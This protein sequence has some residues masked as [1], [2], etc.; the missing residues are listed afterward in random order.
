MFTDTQAEIAAATIP[1]GQVLCQIAQAHYDQAVDLRRVELPRLSATDSVIPVSESD[2]VRVKTYAVE[3]IAKIGHALEEWV[4]AHPRVCGLGSRIVDDNENS[5]L[6]P[7]D[8]RCLIEHLDSCDSLLSR[9]IYLEDRAHSVLNYLVSSV[10]SEES[11]F[12]GLRSRYQDEMNRATGYGGYSSPNGHIGSGIATG[13]AIMFGIAFAALNSAESI[14][15][16]EKHP[17]H[18]KALALLNCEPELL[19]FLSHSLSSAL[20]LTKIKVGPLSRL[21]KCYFANKQALIRC[22]TVDFSGNRARLHMH[23][24]AAK[25]FKQ[26]ALDE[27]KAQHSVGGIWTECPAARAVLDDNTPLTK[28]L[29]DWTFEIVGTF[30]IKRRSFH[31]SYG[32]QSA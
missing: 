4:G 14:A 27:L 13:T 28:Y 16:A 3:A 22:F 15:K 11:V 30:A 31:E 26:T 10:L 32:Q 29:R 23:N 8:R 7:L 18:D 12:I 6:E 25:R 1:F 9:I 17:D 20:A 21:E 24:D 2:A 5:T 19:G